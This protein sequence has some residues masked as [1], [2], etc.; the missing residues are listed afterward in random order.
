[1]MAFSLSLAT[2]ALRY[3]LTKPDRCRMYISRVVVRNFRNFKHLDVSLRPGVTCVIGENN[4]GK[5]NLLHAIRLAIDANLSSTYRQLLEHDIHHGVSL[6]TA[7]QVVVSVE[8]RDYKDDDNECALVGC[9]EIEDN[10][11]RL[12]YRFRAKT[13]TRDEIQSGEREPLGLSHFEDYHFEM[14]G[15]GDND[16]ATVEWDEPLG[17]NLRFADLQAFQVE[18]LPALRDVQQSL[19]QSYSSPLGRLLSVSD[20]SDDEKDTLVGILRTANEQI[21]EQPTINQTGTEIHES[22]A[23]AVGEAFQMNLRLGLSEPSFTSIA[24]SLT[25]LLSNDAISDFDPGRNGLGLNNILYISMLLDYFQK[26]IGNTKA[27]GQLLLIEEPEAH[28]HPQLQRVLY[29]TLAGKGFQ[30]IVTTHSTHISSHAPIESYVTLTNSGKPAIASCVPATAANLSPEEAADVNRF[31][32][33]TRSTLLFARKVLLVEGPAELFLIPVMIKQV[34]GIDLDRQGI[35]VVPIYGTHFAPYAK[36]FASGALEKKCAI[37]CDGD[38]SPDELEDG[39]LEDEA[40]GENSFTELE[41]EFVQVFQCPV[42]FERAIT[43]PWTLRML[44]CAIEECKYPQLLARIKAV[45]AAARD[46]AAAKKPLDK[47]KLDEARKT[48][49]AAAER[50]GKARFAQIASKHAHHVKRLP[51]YIKAAIDWL[52][53]K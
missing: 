34:M 41:S 43:I 29:S 42:T 46:A 27:A 37:L 4:T 48:V 10:L 12:S 19:R 21:E 8:I 9:C 16:P 18:Y 7:D 39:V 2:I 53:E 38:E 31:L 33:A 28:L 26:R 47:D 5:T 17:S 6:S 1:M 25:I 13:K 32:D 23:N 24:R 35:T 52:Q 50:C 44:E 49:L 36:L 11:A 40:L 3:A 14:T 20:I 15:G 51:S 45:R 22:F 30:T